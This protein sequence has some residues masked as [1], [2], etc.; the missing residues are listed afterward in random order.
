MSIGVKNAKNRFY[1]THKDVRGN[2][3][4]CGRDYIRTCK[5]VRR[6]G[7]LHYFRRSTLKQRLPL[8]L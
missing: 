6:V 7:L 2:T 8:A 3:L 4:G 5:G 1:G